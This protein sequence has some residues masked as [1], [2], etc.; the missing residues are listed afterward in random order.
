MIHI[1]TGKGKGKTTAALGLAVRA[2]GAGLRV[3]IAQFLKGSQ[4]SEL[5]S[6]KRL[7]NIT[8][9][10]FGRKCFIKKE[11]KQKDLQEAQR[12]L[13]KVQESIEKSKYDV[14]VLDELNVILQLKMIDS[15]CVAS[16]LRKYG[17]TTEIVLTGRGAPQKIKRLADYITEMKA[18]RHPFTKGARSRKGIEF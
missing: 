6:L 11:P 13:Q 4:S 12:G 10:Q 14:V 15:E 18:V 17:K 9:Q 2:S 16:I 5:N 1:Y 3:Y 8:V 7:K